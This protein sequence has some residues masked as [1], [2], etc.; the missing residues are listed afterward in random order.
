MVARRESQHLRD[1]S[2]QRRSRV[3]AAVGKRDL[4]GYVA[5]GGEFNIAAKNVR[6]RNRRQFGER[7]FTFVIAHD[8]AM[9]LGHAEAESALESSGLA[10]WDGIALLTSDR[11]GPV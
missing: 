8:P 4:H 2:C 10:A 1:H 9:M 6:S 7:F 5:I 11:L 3:G